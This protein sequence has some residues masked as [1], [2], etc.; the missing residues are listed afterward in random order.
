MVQITIS[1]VSHGQFHLVSDLLI[2]IDAFCFDLNVEVI[3]TLN[4]EEII[5][6][7]VSEFSYPIKIIK[8]FKPKGYGENHNNAFKKAF[9]E[10]YCIMNPDIRLKSNPFPELIN[11]IKDCR[12]G[13]CAPM[14]IDKNGAIENSFR[15][16]PNPYSIII[17]LF[18][19]KK[20]DY[21]ST[22][23]IIEP[24]WVAGMFMLFRAS[25]YKKIGGFNERYFLYYEDVEICARLRLMEYRVIYVPKSFVIHIGQ[26]DSR[27]NLKHFS[28]HLK[29]MLRYFFTS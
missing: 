23:K 5:D 18:N 4:I 10:Y 25:I 13:L 27:K 3:L 1:I 6:I 19:K 14:V 22:I 26:Y 15:K 7:E 24:D 16:F 9:G 11:I 20:L 17:K 12:V 2:D 8:N 21:P 28:Y 29:S